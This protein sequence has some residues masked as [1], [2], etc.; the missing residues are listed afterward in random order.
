MSLTACGGCGD[1]TYRPRPDQG[2][3]IV[4]CASCR[5]PLRLSWL[6]TDAWS[7]TGGAR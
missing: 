2:A 1:T 3:D 5:A 6:D 4:E 7:E